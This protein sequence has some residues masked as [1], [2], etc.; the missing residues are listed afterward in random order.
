[1][2]FR[3]LR[4]D[5]QPEFTQIDCEMS[6]I[7]QEDILQT[8]EGLTRHLFQTVKGID[9]GTLP[10]MSY[11]EAMNHYGN[12]KPDIRFEMKLNGLNDLVKGKNFKVLDDAELAI[13]ICVPG[14][15][16]YTRKQLD[17]LT[18]WVKRPQLGMTGLIYARWNADGTFKSSVDKFYSAEDQQKWFQQCGG[19]QGD[20]LLIL[21][22]EQIGRAH[23]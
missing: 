15:A 20:L 17:E 3:S 8:F 16:E 5:R 22:G 12:D 21:A 19:K 23:V 10:R 11:V 2:L 1:M 4:A 7:E 9:I 6:F 14:C 18:E 13:A